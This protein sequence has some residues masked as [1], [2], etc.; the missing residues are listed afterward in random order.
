MNPA[1]VPPSVQGARPQHRQRSEHHPERVLHA[2]DVSGEHGDA[3]PE[4]TTHA[5]VQPDRMP[6][7]VRTRALPGGGPRAGHAVGLLAEQP[8]PPGTPLGGHRQIDVRADHRGGEAHLLGAEARFERADELGHVAVGARMRRMDRQARGCR[9]FHVRQRL[10]QFDERLAQ[11]ARAAATL[12][13]SRAL[14]QDGRGGAFQCPHGR[15]RRPVLVTWRRPL[16]EDRT[17]P[18]HL[19]DEAHGGAGSRREPGGPVRRAVEA[20]AQ[21]SYRFLRGSDRGVA[22]AGGPVGRAVH[23]R[24]L[25]PHPGGKRAACRDQRSAQWIT[26]RRRP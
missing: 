23:E 5:V 2:Q 21:G 6:V 15:I 1:T 25:G 18:A 3:E 14:L 4:S 10:P 9:R 20:T 8:L 13:Q 19:V 12:E 24:D 17:Q 22:V 16:I 7:D 11:G 26:R